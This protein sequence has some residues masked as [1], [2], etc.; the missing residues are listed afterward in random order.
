M[1][2]SHLD[3]LEA[4]AIH[5]FR[6]VKDEPGSMQKKKRWG[7]FRWPLKGKSYIL[8]KILTIGARRNI[9]PC[10]AS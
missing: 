2:L 7:L 8:V 4:D 3:R 1:T 10:C 5:I 9:N 6:E